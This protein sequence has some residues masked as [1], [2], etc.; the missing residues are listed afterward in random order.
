MKYQNEMLI[1]QEKNDA[2]NLEI[3]ELKIIN[4]KQEEVIINIHKILNATILC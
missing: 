1:L 3:E 2:L 4:T